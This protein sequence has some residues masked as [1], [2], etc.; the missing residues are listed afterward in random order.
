MSKRTI[1]FAVLLMGLAAIVQAQIVQVIGKNGI[2][3]NRY[4]AADLDSI[5]YSYNGGLFIHLRDGSV[6][7]FLRSKADSVMWFDPTNSI[8]SSLREEGG[9]TNFVRLVE[10]AGSTS[11]ILSK[12][13][14]AQDLTVFAANDAAWQRFFAA[15]ANLS[16]LD[17]WQ[18]ATSYEA[19]TD[20]QKQALLLGAILSPQRIGDLENTYIMRILTGSTYLPFLTPAFCNRYSIGGDDQRIMF[21]KTIDAPWLPGLQITEMDAERANGYL[22]RISAPLKPLGTMPDVIRTNGRTDIFAHILEKGLVYGGLFF[23]PSQAD[24]SNN[25]GLQ[26][27]MAAMFV[28]SDEEMWRFFTNGIGETLLRDNYVPK[29]EATGEPLPYTAPTS[30]EEL[31]K[32][33]DAIPRATLN[34]I[35]NNHMHASF[36]A[37]V[38]SKWE[39][40]TDYDLNPLFEDAAVARERIDT[41]LF[42]CNGIVYVINNV[43]LPSDFKSVLAPAFVA[44]TCNILKWAIYDKKYMTTYFDTYLKAPRKD[45]TF[46]LPTD[47]A[48]AYYYDP[49]SMKSRTPRAIKFLSINGNIPV[50]LQFFNYY[51]LYNQTK[52][53]I[54]TISST[55]I[56]GSSQYTNEE[57]TNHLK[58]ILL[59]HTIVSDDTQDIHSR[60]E[61]FRTLGGDVVKV[62]RDDNG[63]IVG[64]K[65]TFQIE[66]EHYY[67]KQG[68]DT[69]NV[70]HGVLE[71]KVTESFESL[72]NGRTYTLDAPLVPTYRSLWSLMTNDADM[73]EMLDGT[74]GETPYSEFYKL[75]PTDDVDNLIVGCGIVDGELPKTRRNEALKKFK[76]LIKDTGP[77]YNFAMLKA[78]TPFTAFIPTNQAVQAAIAKG[79]PTWEEINEDFR[80][81]CKTNINEET[82]ETEYT[83]SL[84]SAEDSI[85]IAGKIMTLMNVLKAHFCFDMAIADQ[86][87][88]Q[89][90]Y[91]S[92]AMNENMALRK[93]IVSSPGYGQMMVTDWTGHSFMVTDNKNIFVHEYTC[94]TSPF[95]KMMRGIRVDSHRPGVVHQ[96]NGVLGFK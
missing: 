32:Q 85:R 18:T 67:E 5:S 82:G 61:Y 45:I 35:V 20:E 36:I 51:C 54:G 11:G 62:V 7:K 60:N 37:S 30:S 39:S 66:N 31:L 64:A 46:F 28:P 23:D 89:R 8:L 12:M 55:P 13:E 73:V 94:S 96:I 80:S 86:E 9:Y 44:G 29:D 81:H 42:A 14:G 87:P 77:D 90:E 52:G 56:P 22:E 26:Y 72:S 68:L 93:L 25:M 21:G 78:N 70:E 74:G 27:D 75:L 6:E 58:N 34:A 47:E 40:L 92:F 57:V 69:E 15:N 76:F 59:S 43:N 91:K 71:C 65:G 38:P 88:F 10:E 95:N 49:A 83:D 50:K 4:E 24:Y 63:Q 17:P 53:D 1:A 2:Y 16:S 48:L 19:L 3:L 41:C 33:I 79:L 84:Q